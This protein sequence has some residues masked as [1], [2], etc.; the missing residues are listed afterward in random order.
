MKIYW[1]I[2]VMVVPIWIQAQTAKPMVSQA[3]IPKDFIS[4]ANNRFQI[5]KGTIERSEKSS[6]KKV[7]TDFYLQSNYQLD[8]ILKSGKVIFNEELSNYL[9]KVAAKIQE[10]NPKLKGDLHIYPIKYDFANAFT[11]NEG[12]IFVNI[13]LI[14][15]IENEAELAFILGHEMA[16]YLKKHSV[17]RAVKNQQI[18][19]KTNQEQEALL[20]MSRFSR[21]H[22]FEAD[23][24]GLELLL[25]T[26][27]DPN[28]SIT[29]LEMLYLSD[30][31][32][33]SIPFD[34]KY[35]EAGTLRIPSTLLT[36]PAAK[37]K[38]V[39][40]KAELSEEEINLRDSLSSHPAIE[41]RVQILKG[42]LANTTAKGN[43]FQ[44]AT[45][46][47][48]MK[49]RIICREEMGTLYAANDEY[50]NGIYH[51]YL[52]QEK[53]SE[54]LA[55][56]LN[57]SILFAK[58]CIGA[59]YKNYKSLLREGK[60][61]EEEDMADE[62]QTKM[63]QLLLNLSPE[64]FHLIAMKQAYLTSAKFPQD[65]PLLEI[66]ELLI[67]TYREWYGRDL[68]AFASLKEY[69]DTTIES[70]YHSNDQAPK[71]KDS[72]IKKV[73]AKK[74][75]SNFENG[76]G[77]YALSDLIANDPNFVSSYNKYAAKTIVVSEDK[78]ADEEEST[79]ETSA[80]SKAV[81]TKKK[82]EKPKIPGHLGA[83]K[84]LLMDPQYTKRD[85]RKNNKIDFVGDE[86][87]E[88]KLIGMIETAGTAAGLQ[89]ELLAP[90]EMNASDIDKFNDY[91]YLK[92][93]MAESISHGEHN[94]PSAYIEEINAIKDRYQTRYLTVIF[95]RAELYKHGIGHYL[96]GWYVFLNQPFLG[97]IIL[98]KGFFPKRYMNLVV[99]IF[100][101]EENRIIY[102]N[103]WQ[104]KHT[105]SPDLLK[106]QFY[107][108]FQN[109]KTH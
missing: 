38:S 45:E 95:T 26:P 7:K 8:Y 64:E 58:L 20:K 5:E 57:K 53:E 63:K 31:P 14:A 73:K 13:G 49:L 97:G 72:R 70:L 18:A 100:D 103:D 104:Y 99:G 36:V 102:F 86:K 108:I 62:E 107:A 67:R 34:K 1:M 90:N 11:F 81:T 77:R 33:A 92:S 12:Y 25:N 84:I 96:G 51:N 89:I 65:K 93:W 15:R 101:L 47:E 71:D 105:D 22:E 82:A 61:K 87:T 80:K 43:L 17:K 2:L 19:S 55:T 109:I 23:M 37:K 106:S 46:A 40:L 66:S 74:K 32:V 27:Y 4:P 39:E 52:L 79:E 50:V 29:A 44:V 35:L 3:P 83:N 10:H 78:E 9:N 41:Q 6:V 48:F 85:Y 42:K 75:K 91:G 69:S 56:A 28:A 60:E 98:G 76:F 68:S 30:L 24:A 59:H 16:H 21:E 54:S 94:I 88:Q